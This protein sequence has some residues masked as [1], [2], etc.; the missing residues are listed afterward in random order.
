M[1]TILGLTARRRFVPDCIAGAVLIRIAWILFIQPTPTSDSR[2]YFDT[3]VSLSNGGGY[4]ADG[5]PTAWRPPGY[6][7]FLALLFRV[8]WPS[9]AV[10]AVGNVALYGLVL[11]AWY[12]LVRR[13][14][15][16]DPIARLTLLIL[17]VYPN[18]IAYASLIASETLALLLATLGLLLIA[19][20]EERPWVVPFAGV[21]FGLGAFVRPVLLLLPLAVGMLRAV[22]SRGNATKKALRSVAATL[23]VTY[24]AMGAVQL[25]WLARNLAVFGHYV[26]ANESGVTLLVGNNPYAN[27]GWRIDDKVRA[28][29]PSTGDEFEDSVRATDYALDYIQA[30]PF[31]TLGLVPFKIGYLYAVDHDGA[32]W[33]LRGM[34]ADQRIQRT[35]LRAWALISDAFYWLILL[36]AAVTLWKRRGAFPRLG[37]TLLVFF[38]VVYLPFFGTSRF[39]FLAAPW[40]VLAAALSLVR[41]ETRV[42]V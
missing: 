34:E 39:H 30:H 24:L 20:S 29:I 2:F 40:L 32:A 26:F 35:A 16:S 8:F 6:S 5:E 41:S 36:G 17:A 28:L 3:A 25:P 42:S 38:T 7:G 1:N 33:N 22:E 19:L 27:G 14:T 21:A 13:L 23:L 11:V 10:A 12:L 9:S 31:R 4:I 18:H 15:H 37:V